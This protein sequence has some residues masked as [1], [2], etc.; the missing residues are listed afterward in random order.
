[1][2]HL[3]GRGCGGFCFLCFDTLGKVRT[4]IPLKI[5]VCEF[6]VLFQFEQTSEFSV[7]KNPSPICRIL[8]LV[9]SNISVDFTSYLCASHLGTV[10]F[11]KEFSKLLANFSWFYKTTW[12]TIS[13]FANAF[14]TCFLCIFKL[15]LRT[16]LKRSNLSCYT[17]KL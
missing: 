16:F 5:E 10:R 9:C 12:G 1:M 15:A 11:S 3:I 13:T 7:S 8:K 6:I 14:A 17:G 4:H 2:V